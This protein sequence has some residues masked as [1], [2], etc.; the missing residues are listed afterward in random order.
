MKKILAIFIALAI[1]GCAHFDG[2]LTKFQP[3]RQ[4]DN[5]QVYLFTTTANFIYPLNSKEAENI[6]IGWLEKQLKE[7]GLN[8]KDYKILER[9]VVKADGG[10]VNAEA[11]HLYYEVLANKMF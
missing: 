5:N 8:E 2:H 10:A 1:T 4:Q 11:Y 3:L 6:R 7:H 9:K